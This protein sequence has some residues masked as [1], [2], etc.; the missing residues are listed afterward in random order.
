MYFAGLRLLF[1][2]TGPVAL[3][4]EDPSAALLTSLASFKDPRDPWTSQEASTEA[5]ALL[6]HYLDG[7][8]GV[9]KKL[10]ALL[11][12]LLREK[13]K[14]LFAKSKSKEI[15]EQG[16]KAISAVPCPFVSSDLEATI[17]P[18]KHQDVYIVTVLKWILGQLTV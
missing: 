3:L 1:H 17:K 5:H 6:E 18:W 7:T 9:P 13:V 16:R 14:P 2:L 11:T 15:T 4:N 10:D 12:A 8:K